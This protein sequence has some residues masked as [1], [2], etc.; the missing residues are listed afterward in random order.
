MNLQLI[1]RVQAQISDTLGLNALVAGGCIRDHLCNK[2]NYK[3]ID[4]FIP[5]TDYDDFTEKI[6]KL[7]PRFGEGKVVGEVH[8]YEG[9]VPDTPLIGVREYT[10]RFSTPL[11]IVGQKYT[12]EASGFHEAVFNRFDFGI[13]C[14]GLDSHT[15][16]DMPYAR[17]DRANHSITI[18]NI[19]SPLQLVK[20]IDKYKRLTE[21]KYRGWILNY[22]NGAFH[23]GQI[24]YCTNPCTEI[25]LQAVRPEV[26][27]FDWDAFYR[28]NQAFFAAI[29]QTEQ[30]GG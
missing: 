4:V 22:Y 20:A 24:D 7:S 8:T 21:T 13:N 14:C 19:W 29:E 12:G 25:Q 15:I 27:A 10:V 17:F 6:N 18:L 2:S 5:V 1:K 26:S 28:Q 11:Q 3:D 30:T 9:G 16:I 23:N